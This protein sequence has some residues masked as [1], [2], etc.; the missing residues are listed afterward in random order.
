MAKDS[1]VSRRDF[2]RGS[3]TTAAGLAAL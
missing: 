1:E 3:I 2:L